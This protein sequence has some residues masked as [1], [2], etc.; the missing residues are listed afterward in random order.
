[1]ARYIVSNIAILTAYRIVSYIAIIPS[2]TIRYF[3]LLHW[4]ALSVYNRPR[5]RR[6]QQRAIDWRRPAG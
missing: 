2:E 3:A 4:G 1:M 6:H 5:T